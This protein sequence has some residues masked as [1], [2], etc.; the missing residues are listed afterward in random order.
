MTWP[1]VVV[2]GPGGVGSYFGGMLA[3]AGASVTMLGRPGTMSPHLATINTSGLRLDAVTFD[4][5]V[6]VVA[7]ANP[8]VVRHADLVLFCVKTPDT[9]SAA[10][11]IAAHLPPRTTVLDLQNG[12]ENPET[13]RRHGI[14]PVVAVVYVA[15][16]VDTPGEVK[17]RGRGDLVL[18]CSHTS[19]P[20][21]NNPTPRQ[22]AAWFIQAGVPCRLSE[23]IDREAWLKL[24]LNSM[25]NA[26]SALTDASYGA[27][28]SFEP[29]WQIA[30]DVAREGV[31][32]AGAVGFDFEL[33]SVIRQGLEVCRTVGAATSSTQQDIA[34]R[35]PTEID[36]LNGCIARLG[37]THSITTPANRMLWALV[38]LREQQRGAEPT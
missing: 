30:I 2:V 9:S 10:K 4:E 35:R 37:K 26:I 33:P 27:L 32:V 19:A 3:R 12:V 25:A 22:V 31:E 21:E 11:A 1:K 13:L 23:Q 29:S 14:D 15:A 8:A 36:A 34:H 7:A 17:H 24:I 28:V 6:A 5:R 18:G 16:A 20:A 38:K